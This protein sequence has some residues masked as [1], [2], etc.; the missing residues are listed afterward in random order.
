M[1]PTTLPDEALD[2]ISQVSN[3]VENKPLIDPEG[4]KQELLAYCNDFITKS[5]SWRS[6]SYEDKWRRFQ[7][8]ADGIYEPELAAAKEKWQSKVHVGITASHRESIHAYLFKIMCGTNPPLEISSRFDLGEQDQ[9]KN[10]RDIILRELD[11][12]RWE[13]EFD[14]TMHDAD[15]FGSGFIRRYWKTETA[16]RKLKKPVTELIPN[17][18]NPM[19]EMA[20]YVANKLKTSYQEDK[21]KVITYRGLKVQNVSIWDVFKTPKAL[22]IPGSTIAIRYWMTYGDL[23]KGVNE[24]YHLP[25][26]IKKLKGAATSRKFSPGESEVNADRNVTDS[27]IAAPDYGK[28]LE[29]Y[30]LFGK[31]PK[32]WI[33]SIIGQELSGDIEEL[34]SARVIFHKICPVAVEVNDEYDGEPPIHQLNHFPKNGDSYGLGIPEMLE[35]PQ[36][37][38]NEIVNQR[39]DNGAQSLNH[40]FAVIESALVNPKEDLKSK[41]SCVLRL[42]ANKVPNGVAANAIAELPISDVPSR[43]GF[44]EVNEWERFAQERTSANRVTLG[45]AGLVNDSNQTLGGQQMLKESAGE[46]FAYIG[47]MMELGFSQELFHGIWKT[48]YTNI[49]PQDIEDSIGPERAQSFILITP[50]EIMRDYIYKPMGVFGMETKAV[51]QARILQIRDKFIGAPWI[52]DEKMY[53]E[54]CRA[55]DVD[56][57]M[58]KKTDE[59]VMQDQAM[60]IPMGEEGQ[61]PTDTMGVPMQGQGTA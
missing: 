28:E 12:T 55:G 43:A 61:I 31:L 24:G 23:V 37:V 1:D 16:I 6:S 40:H 33:Y 29:F 17:D 4:A 10:I 36:A 20:G 42:N 18:I 35:T 41:A 52:D 53:D 44:S 11:K 25:E 14:S 51:R 34:I 38:I 21:V 13:V 46:K 48:V 49:D 57:D 30:E 45:T 32:K 54:T 50:E 9:S 2:Y 3:P 22:K 15:T 56:G 59:Q 60:Q 58:F 8:A 39:L 26:T 19:G 47:L 7:R 27:S 5:A